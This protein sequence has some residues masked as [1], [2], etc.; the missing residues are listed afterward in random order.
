VELLGL[1]SESLRLIPVDDAY[2]IDVPALERA[3][4]ADHA[5]GLQPFSLIGHAG[6]VNSGAIDPLETLAGIAAR[7]G[8]WFHVDG[9]IGAPAVLA[10]DLRPKLAGMSRA[11]F[12]LL[13]REVV[14]LGH[15]VVRF[16]AA[17]RVMPV[18][19]R[20]RFWGSRGAAPAVKSVL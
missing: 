18:P 7:E 6:T 17:T 16:D 19:D 1:G 2:R 8:L 12:D 20:E 4:G 9:A 10:P 5:A 3:L 15:V 14:R 11:D 13:V